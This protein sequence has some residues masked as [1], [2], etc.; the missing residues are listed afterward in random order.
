MERRRNFDIHFLGLKNAIHYFE[1]EIGASFFKLYEKSLISEAN[2]LV[3]LSLDKK[4]SFF[5]LNFQVDGLV[6]LPCDRCNELFD[7]ELMTDFE[8][9]V[10]FEEVENG[11]VD[12]ADVVYISRNET[13]I[14]VADLIYDY[15]LINIPI[16][17]FHPNDKD[18]NS[19]CNPEILEKLKTLPRV[20]EEIDPRWSSLNKLKSK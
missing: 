1:Y 10:K 13:S 17:V 12:E 9:I 19:T 7:Y 6:N 16:Q 8:I 4:D 20:E 15:I 3:K 14:N 5:I 2:L 18:G 11:V